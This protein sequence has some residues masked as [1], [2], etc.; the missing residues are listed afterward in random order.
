[1]KNIYNHFYDNTTIFSSK[2]HSHCQ[3]ESIHDPNSYKYLLTSKIPIS[4]FKPL[5]KY[6]HNLRR[7]KKEKKD[8]TFKTKSSS[9]NPLQ[10]YSFDFLSNLHPYKYSE[11]KTKMRNESSSALYN[12]TKLQIV[13]ERIRK[14]EEKSASLEALNDIFF[15]VF[16]NVIRDKSNQRKYI[17]KSIK[18]LNKRKLMIEPNEYN[19][20]LNYIYELANSE[21]ISFDDNGDMKNDMRNLEGKFEKFKKEMIDVINQNNANNNEA[22]SSIRKGI[23]N[24]KNDFMKQIQQ[25]NEQGNENVRMVE[26]F[27]QNYA[28]N[29][30]SHKS[31]S[32]EI[33]AFSPQFQFDKSDKTLSIDSPKKPSPI[34]RP[35][36]KAINSYS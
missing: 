35:R 10:F 15:S 36:R 12:A 5:P 32:K 26:D 2:P 24:I 34:L 29:K 16:H 9:I 21:D 18:A 14:L 28:N 6:R 17:E 7:R 20:Q 1:M 4:E 8:F 27:I 13:E 25:I 22:M 19:D 30:S 3:T 31:S 33:F 11:Q 23:D